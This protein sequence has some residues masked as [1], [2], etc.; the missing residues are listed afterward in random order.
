[1][2]LDDETKDALGNT[3]LTRTTIA[4]EKSKILMASIP[5]LFESGIRGAYEE[6]ITLDFGT[7]PLEGVLNSEGTAYVTEGELVRL[8][9]AVRAANTLKNKTLADITGKISDSNSSVAF[10]NKQ[11]L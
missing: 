6:A 7:T 10:I 2:L 4:L 8:F 1:M 3:E 11:F 9:R 5:S